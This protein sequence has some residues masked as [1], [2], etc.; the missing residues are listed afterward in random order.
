MSVSEENLKDLLVTAVEGGINYW[1]MV[2]KY[3]PDAGSVVVIEIESSGEG[4]PIKRLVTFAD[5]REPLKRLAAQLG[6]S[7]EELFENHDAA[8][9]DALVQMV[10]FGEVI[11]A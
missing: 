3:D 5:L 9:A 8:T 1:A 2:R 10:L 6:Q 7:P 4:A 11:Y